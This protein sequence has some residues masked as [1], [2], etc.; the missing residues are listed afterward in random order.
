[1]RA[2]SWSGTDWP[3]MRASSSLLLLGG[4]ATQDT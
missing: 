3:A 1:M 4:V 2:A